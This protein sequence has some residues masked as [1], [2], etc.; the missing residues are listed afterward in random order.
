MVE[1]RLSQI[2]GK[3][4][5]SLGSEKGPQDSEEKTDQC[6]DQHHQARAKNIR[7]ISTFNS[8][9]HQTPHQFRDDHFANHFSNH[10]DRGQDGHPFEF[11]DLRH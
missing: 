4:C 1:H 9:V 11:L 5:G 8:P 6:N 2:P 10:P 3:P 7:Q